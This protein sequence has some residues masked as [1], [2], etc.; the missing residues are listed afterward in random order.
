MPFMPSYVVKS[1]SCLGPTHSPITARV[2]PQ[3][4]APLYENGEAGSDG[5]AWRLRI[6]WDRASLE[7]FERS[8]AVERLERFEQVPGCIAC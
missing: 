2:Y 7:R 4:L 1:R 6:R 8:D 5:N 3:A